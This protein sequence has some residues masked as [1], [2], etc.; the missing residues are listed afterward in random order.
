[1]ANVKIKFSVA[2][3]THCDNLYIVGSNSSLGNW[4]IKKATKLTFSEES[5]AFVCC[6]MLPVGETVEFKFVSAK[7][8]TA[9]EKGIFN[10][11]IANRQVVPA[12]GM[13]LD[14]TIEN[15]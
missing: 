8:W 6:K 3:K 13:K 11:D 7:D 14:L 15:I 10:E 2:P 4:N 5:N 1:M 9:V 12:K